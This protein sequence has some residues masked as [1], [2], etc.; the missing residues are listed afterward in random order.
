MTRSVEDV[1]AQWAPVLDRARACANELRDRAAGHEKARRVSDEAMAALYQYH[2]LRH[3]HPKRHGG[4]GMPW[5]IQ[6]DIGRLLA[7]GCPSTAWVSTVVAGNNAYA[8]RF[9]EAAQEE[10]YGDSHDVL[11]T[12]ASVQIGV[13]M[14]K[15]GD[16]FRLSGRWK[17]ASGIDH[18]H[19][20]LVSATP[21]DSDGAPAGTPYFMLIP[22]S[23]Y[24]IDDT[25]F[26]SGMRGTGSKDIVVEDALVPAHRALP[27][28]TFWG[29]DPPGARDDEGFIWRMPLAGYFGTSL[30]GPIVGIAEGGIDAYT[31]ITGVRVGVMSGKTV[32]DEPTVQLRLA[33]SRAEV[34]TARRVLRAQI[35]Q[36]REL[37]E[38][39]TGLDPDTARAMTR[40]RA[41]ATRMCQNALERLAS[42]MGAMGIF[43]GNPVQRYMRD[44][45]AASTQI[46]VNYDRGM[47]P[48]GQQALGLEPPT[49]PF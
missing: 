8:C 13:T 44:L 20:V 24:T 30:L 4:D 6:F 37:G 10:V 32:A 31:E 3:F 9:P 39:G 29:A 22:A 1:E 19:W 36:L 46:A 41:F 18:A 14:T 49:L 40:D 35:H 34:E 27:A 21:K 16:D 47:I 7:H 11:A 26:V 43:D 33:E 42:T 5:G 28:A 17:F 38:A 12:N 25:W 23:D 15:E 2:L 48:F 45:N